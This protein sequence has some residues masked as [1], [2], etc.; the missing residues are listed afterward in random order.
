MSGDVGWQYEVECISTEI[1]CKVWNAAN[2]EIIST[3][4]PYFY[5]VFRHQAAQ[6]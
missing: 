5:I 6:S 2:S 1:A 3:L 4:D